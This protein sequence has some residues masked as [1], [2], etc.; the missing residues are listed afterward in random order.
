M[1]TPEEF[2][3]AVDAYGQKDADVAL[4]MDAI[5]AMTPAGLMLRPTHNGAALH[6]HLATEPGQSFALFYLRKPRARV[7]DLELCALAWAA[8]Q[9]IAA[10]LANPKEDPADFRA[11]C[12][13]LIRGDGTPAGMQRAIDLALRG[14]GM[15]HDTIKPPT[16]PAASVEPMPPLEP[17]EAARKAGYTVLEQEPGRWAYNAPLGIGCGTGY[18]T[19]GAA[20]AGAVAAHGRCIAPGEFSRCVEAGYAVLHNRVGNVYSFDAPD[21]SEDEAEYPTAR[22]AWEA[23][24]NHRM[25]GAADWPPKPG[26]EGGFAHYPHLCPSKHHNR[27]DDICADCGECLQ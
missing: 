25:F 27:G 4:T 8:V 18:R 3:A 5:R 24:D 6:V 14:L 20:W 7:H 11:S 9:G 22:A 13:E 10:H 12:V 17:I 16:T 21:G 1:P 19:E 26:P 2:G 15:G 23:A